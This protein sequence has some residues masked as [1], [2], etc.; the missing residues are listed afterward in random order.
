LNAFEITGTDLSMSIANVLAGIPRI[1]ESEN[2]VDMK[3]EPLSLGLARYLGDDY[4]TV[5]RCIELCRSAL[6]DV[7]S[8]FKRIDID[9][10]T[11]PALIGL[12]HNRAG[13]D[14]T[15]DLRIT[16]AIADYKCPNGLRIETRIMH[17]DHSSAMIA[18]DQALT[19]LDTNQAEFVLV[20]GIESYIHN[21]TLRDLEEKKLLKTSYNNSGLIPG[22][23]ASFCLLCSDN[24]AEK[25]QLKS[26]ALINRFSTHREIHLPGSSEPTTGAAITQAIKDVLDVLPEGEVVNEVFCSLTGS[27]QE[28]EEYGYAMMQN[29]LKIERPAEYSSTYSYWGD[30]GTAIGPALIGYAIEKHRLGLSTGANHLVLAFSPEGKRSAVLLDLK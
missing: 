11:V 3:F 23:A 27:N 30:V 13:L 4:E 25:Y 19:I 6:D 2:W 16:A 17:E 26:L 9:H 5:F 20:G 21:D 29:G 7:L 12:P 18:F 8:V 28:A 10:K 1:S 24:T 22:E 15:L 14:H